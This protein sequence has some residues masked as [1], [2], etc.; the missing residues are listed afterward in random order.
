VSEDLTVDYQKARALQGVSLNV[1]EGGSVWIIGANG[2]GKTAVLRTISGLK[3]PTSGKIVFK[4][5]A[6][7]LANDERVKQHYLGSKITF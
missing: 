1:D 3:I 6:K 2:A 4:G 5:D 7:D